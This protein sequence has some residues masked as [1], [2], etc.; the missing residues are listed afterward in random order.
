M[1]HSQCYCPNCPSKFRKSLLIVRDGR[2]ALCS[3]YK[4]QTSLKNFEGS[5]SEFLRDKDASQYGN[6]WSEWYRSWVSASETGQVEFVG[7]SW[8][9][10]PLLKKNED[11]SQN[12][13]QVYVLRYEDLK[14]N[15]VKALGGAM[16]FLAPRG[17]LPLNG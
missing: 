2:S 11:T 16:E 8:K 12:A 15:A 6:S 3:Y 5:F 10:F 7:A 9:K 4:F 17:L 1:E 14:D 13:T